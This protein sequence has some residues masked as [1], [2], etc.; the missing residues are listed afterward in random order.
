MACLFHYYLLDSLFHLDYILSAFSYPFCSICFVTFFFLFS[1]HC[2]AHLTLNLFFFL[3][4]FVLNAAGRGTGLGV[5]RGT[6]LWL[7]AGG[8]ERPQSRPRTNDRLFN[9]S[10]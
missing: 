4:Y 3:F 5:V 7:Q 8:A 10:R 9:I 6:R 1:L 2:C